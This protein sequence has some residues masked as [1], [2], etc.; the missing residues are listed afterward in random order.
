MIASIQGFQIER[1]GIVDDEPEGRKT[2]KLAID[3]MD[4]ESILENGPLAALDDYVPD[5][6]SRVSAALCDYHLKT[7]GDYASYDG[8]ELAARLYQQN[9]PAV[10]CTKY[11]D[12]EVTQMR[13]YRRF[14]PWVM[15]YDEAANPDNL[16]HAFEICINEFKDNFSVTRRPWRT[17]VRFEE[18][19][20]DGE[21]CYVV[22]PGWDAQKRIR[23]LNSDCPDSI[24]KQAKK[25]QIRCHA[26]V[27]IGAETDENLYFTEWEA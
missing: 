16:V 1:V 12:W 17:L 11:S 24:L 15:S 23:L 7:R 5:L 13:C 21:Y 25:G 2:H 22:V 9:I 8:D 4:A 3:D 18:F 26:K 20:E 27:N 10:L 19:D 14:I 6:K